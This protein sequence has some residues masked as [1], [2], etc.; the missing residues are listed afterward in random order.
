M[1]LSP[2]RSGSV[3]ATFTVF[4]QSIDRDQVVQF[5]DKVLQTGRL[6]EMP[7]SSVEVNSTLSKFFTLFHRTV[8]IEA[9]TQRCSEKNNTFEKFGKTLGKKSV[10]ESLL[11]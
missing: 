2:F 7:V 3:I 9:G 8:S 4:Y 5:M 10:S 1:K 11:Y 6:S